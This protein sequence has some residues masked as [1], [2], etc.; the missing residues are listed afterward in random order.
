MPPD[1]GK[2]ILE[3]LIESA[4]QG[5]MP[6]IP[7]WQLESRSFDRELP[8]KA[9]REILKS[10]R[11][12]VLEHLTD[13]IAG[14]IRNTMQSQPDEEILEMPLSRIEWPEEECRRVIRCLQELKTVGDI[15]SIGLGNL[16]QT[17]AGHKSVG[18]RIAKIIFIEIY[19]LLPSL[20][21]IEHPSGRLS[22]GC[23]SLVD[24]RL[25]EKIDAANIKTIGDMLNMG[26]DR[27]YLQPLISRSMI[28]KIEEGLEK[29]DPSLVD[30]FYR[31]ASLK[32]QNRFSRD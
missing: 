28:H 9:A 15:L 29:I 24:R 2:T 7:G 6:Q 19:K 18:E 22:I 25:R 16:H 23:L 12:A 11:A 26:V 5:I 17:R 13:L 30:L 1:K 31:N 20:A 3:S 27:F 32:R 14:Q 8:E 10:D 21:P 4:V